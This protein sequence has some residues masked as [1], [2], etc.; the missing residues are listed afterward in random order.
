MS[1]QCDI[2]T[3]EYNDAH[4]RTCLDWKCSGSQGTLRAGNAYYVGE[5]DHQIG[6]L[7]RVAHED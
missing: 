1:D 5:E 3:R 4:P 7:L 6:W 2:P